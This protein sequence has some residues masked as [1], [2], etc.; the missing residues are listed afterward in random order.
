MGMKRE[1]DK[2]AAE[3]VIGI[4]GGSFDPI[5]TGH[6][7][8]A[9][10]AL[11]QGVVA[12]VWLM[13][14]PENPLKRGRLH[15]P[16]ADRLAMARLAVADIPEQEIRERIKVS[17]FEF[18]MPRPSYTIDTLKAL[19]KAYPGKKFKWIA[20]GDNLLT[21]KRWKSPDEILNSYGLILYPRPEYPSG[22][23][24]PA[25]VTMLRGVPPFTESSTSIRESLARGENPSLLPIASGVAEY[26][27]KEGK[28]NLYRL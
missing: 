20:G 4:F 6:I 2:S 28:Q 11:R 15:A 23:N 22:D 24:L 19:S 1:G 26:L 8:V 21:L 17:D 5:H 10:G 14:S 12:E 9:E 25:G 7:A 27:V 13:V 18:N 3:D 16:E